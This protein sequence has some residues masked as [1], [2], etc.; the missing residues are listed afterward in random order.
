[1]W[2]IQPFVSLHYIYLD[3]ESF[4]ESGAGGVSLRVESRQ[5]DSLVSEL[6]ARIT[7]V[8]RIKNSSLIPEISAAWNYD[9]DVDDRMITASFA[10][11]P[12]TSF[13]VRGQDVEQHGATVGAGLTFISKGGLSASLKYNGEFRENYQAHGILAGLRYEF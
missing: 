9:F 8:F 6:G 4:R 11:A 12:G 10:G 2:I 13:S 5:T 3:E 7:R 1:N